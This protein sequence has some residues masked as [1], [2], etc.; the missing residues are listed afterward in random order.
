MTNDEKEQL[1][2]SYNRV[3]MGDLTNFEH[4]LFNEKYKPSGTVQ[5]MF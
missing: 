4:R 2:Y 3:D 5:Y 1:N